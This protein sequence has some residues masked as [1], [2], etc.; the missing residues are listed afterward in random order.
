[1]EP[2][3]SVF[4]DPEI[5]RTVLEHMQTGTYMV[6]CEQKLQ[7]WNDGAENI[8]GHLRQDVVGHFLPG[9]FSTAKGS[10]EKRSLRV[11][12]RAGERAARR[13]AGDGGSNAAAQGRASGDGACA[14][15]ADA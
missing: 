15:G 10:R 8:T 11:G 14:S 9:F 3:M 13:Q 5:Y 2:S 1:M 12:G 4:A 7:F 6:D